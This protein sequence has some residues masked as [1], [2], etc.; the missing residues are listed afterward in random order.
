MNVLKGLE[1]QSVLKYFEEISQ[2]PRG[3]GNEKGISDFL[4]NFGKSLGLETIQDE[5]LNVII[6]KPATPGYENA[7][8]VIIQGHMDMVCEKNKDTIHDFEKDPIELRVDGDYIYATGTT[9]GADNGI[10][11]AY[12]MAVLASNDIAHP[13]IE[14]LVTTDEEVGMGGAIALDGTLLKGKYLLNIDSEEE[15]KLLVSCAGGARS[16]VTLPINFEEMEKDFEVYEIMLRGLKG[17]HSGMEIDKQRGNSNKLMGRVLND[18]NANCDI[19]L[20]SI[21][22][23]SKVNAIP[24]ECD[25][26]LA[27]KKE[28][29]KKLEELIQKWDSILKDEY[30]ANDSGVNV[31]LVKKEENHKVFSKDT[32]F[33]AIKIMNLIPD[34]VDTYSIEMKGLVQSSTNLGVVTTEG[35][36]IVFASSTR[37]SVETLK[38]KLLDEIADVAEIGRAHV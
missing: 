31:T 22:G 13:A 18:I 29:I 17:G 34:G 8:G 19:R 16:E 4:V 12:G 33:K 14:L 25:T 9:L 20:I 10:A 37:S 38:T 3:S 5:S 36:K 1:P 23:G 35:D 11:V 30:H 7:P 28:D 32:T 24:R 21:N 26:L 27:V 15:G 2:I 6:R